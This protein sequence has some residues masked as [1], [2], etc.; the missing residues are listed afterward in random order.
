M[1]EN[2]KQVMSETKISFD[3]EKLVTFVSNGKGSATVVQAGEAIAITL[4]K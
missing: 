4:N 2:E 3:G 1:S